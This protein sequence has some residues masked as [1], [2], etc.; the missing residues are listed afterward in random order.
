MQ[1]WLCTRV[2]T[3]RAADTTRADIGRLADGT[4]IGVRRLRAELADAVRRAAHGERLVVTS[5]GAPSAV[6][7]P[8]TESAPSVD[9]LISSGALIVP[10]R[11]GSWRA[12]TPVQIW[13]GTRI[14]QALREL[15]G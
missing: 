11:L 4:H 7:G 9:Q 6:L 13:A 8:I 14:D 10:R 3:Q 15:R 12:P 5:G 1:L 2:D